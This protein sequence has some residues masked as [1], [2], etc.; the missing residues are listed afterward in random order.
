MIPI[1]PGNSPFYP[2]GPAGVPAVAGLVGQP[3]IVSWRPLDSGRRRGF[4]T[5][6]SDR[7]VAAM[8]GVLVGWDYN[9]ALS[10]SVSK[11]RSAFTGGYL[12]DERIVTGLAQ[13]ILNPFGAQTPAGLAYLNNS[14]LLGEYLDAR[15][16]SSG[17]DV[18]ATRDLMTMAGGPLGFAAGIE[19]RRDKVQYLVNRALASQASSSGYQDALDQFGGRHMSA[20]FAEANLPFHRTLEVNLALRHDNYSDFGG[21]TNPK[22]ALRWQPLPQWLVRASY[23][24]GFRAPTLFEVNAPETSTNTA[25]SYNDPLLCPGGVPVPGANPI[26]SCDQQQQIRSGGNRNL[27]PEKSKTYSAGVVFEPTREL[28]VGLDYWDIRLRDQINELAEQTIF[29]DFNRYRSLFFY[30]AAGTQL[31]YILSNTS[32]LGEVRSRGIDLSLNFRLP[33][34]RWGNFSAIMEGTWVDKYEYQN[35]RGGAF[36]QNV[37]RFADEGPIFRWRHN[38]LLSWSQGPWSANLGN[39]FMSRYTDQNNP[40]AIAPQFF[41]RVGS[42]NTWSLAGTY[43][44]RQADYTLGVKNLTDREPPYSNQNVTFQQGYDQRFGDAIGRTYYAR[45]TTRF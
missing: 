17:V 10:H 31:D 21:T 43:T 18:R 20:I 32:N 40:D 6:I 9:A 24:R 8:E 2:G 37:G 11:A 41:R 16:R 22:V 7:F 33:R 27:D 14:L 38:L 12:I 26:I 45:V 15:M 44:A 30:N 39:R 13:G 35:E 4:D 28:T 5:S 42:N 19:Y 3:L 34:M 1:V 36:I 29:G 25:G 23:N